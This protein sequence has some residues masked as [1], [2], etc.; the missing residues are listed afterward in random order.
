[1]HSQLALFGGTRLTGWQQQPNTMK[2]DTIQTAYSLAWYTFG[3]IESKTVLP[4]TLPGLEVAN[5]QNTF[6][7]HSWDNMQIG[8]PHTYHKPTT[9]MLTTQQQKIKPV[10]AKS[11]IPCSK[12]FNW[13]E[14]FCIILRN[15]HGCMRTS[16]KISRYMTLQHPNTMKADTI[17]TRTRGQNL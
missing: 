12:P 2:A 8:V 5:S 9:S 3:I 1:M 10:Y 11:Q 4:D 13:N 16:S 7:I 14:C 15:R 6:L 17:Q